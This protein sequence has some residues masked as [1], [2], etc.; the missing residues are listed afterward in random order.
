M[1]EYHIFS[2][3]LTF[4]EFSLL[5]WYWANTTDAVCVT[6]TKSRDNSLIVIKAIG[7]PKKEYS[8]VA[9]F[10]KH[11]ISSSAEYPKYEI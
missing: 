11:D 7:I 8:N 10:P 2:V 3:I 5:F 4:H 9:I 6:K 1:I